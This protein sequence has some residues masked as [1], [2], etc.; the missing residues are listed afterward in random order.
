[1]TLGELALLPAQHPDA[2][3][4][5]WLIGCFRRRSITFFSG[6]CDSSTEVYWLQTR[7]I[8]V[9]LRISPRRPRAT[10]K[11]SLDDFTESE[12]A[13]LAR[14][15]GGAART[16]WDGVSMRWFDWAAF[17]IHDKW[18]EPGCLRRIGDCVIELAPSGAYVEDWRMQPSSP[19]PVV[20]LQLIEER[21]PGTGEV[22]HRGGALIVCGD[23]A[24]LARGRSGGTQLPERELFS[25]EA[26]YALRD[27]ASGDFR[28]ALSTNPL[29]EG[30]ILCVRDGFEMDHETHMVHQRVYENGELRERIFSIDTLEAR[31]DFRCSTDVSIGAAEWL[32]SEAETLLAH[33]EGTSCE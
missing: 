11:A 18:P 8:C 12:L 1:M 4:P 27:P 19:G 7:G 29:R 20:G 16:G 33:A 28:I 3:A 25:C 10:G 22:T 5:D 2:P 17:Q 30:Q 23:H 6:Q 14:A 21:V 24:A 26:S 32:A 31:N 9:D 15:E 13:L